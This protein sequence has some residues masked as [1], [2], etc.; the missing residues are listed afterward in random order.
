MPAPNENPHQSLDAKN[1]A[2]SRS[3]DVPPSPR[4]SH[5]FSL[6]EGGTLGRINIRILQP[7]HRILVF[8]WSFWQLWFRFESE[9][10]IT[11][12]T[13][14]SSGSSSSKEHDDNLHG[15]SCYLYRHY[16]A[17]LRLDPSQD[18]WLEARSR[19]IPNQTCES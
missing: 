13:S 8:I 1:Q 4:P 9:T 19:S 7:Q 5:S 6:F 17:E 14:S 3:C 16:N 15:W 18:Q 11:T 2:S 10:C 12:I